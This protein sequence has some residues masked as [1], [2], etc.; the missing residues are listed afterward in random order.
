MT[1]F[2]DVHNKYDIIFTTILI[3]IIFLK[4]HTQQ[5]VKIEFLAFLYEFKNLYLPLIFTFNYSLKTLFYIKIAVFIF[6]LTFQ[7]FH[8]CRFEYQ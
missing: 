6:S 1:Y 2:I 3:L 4:K 5:A 8:F 7:F